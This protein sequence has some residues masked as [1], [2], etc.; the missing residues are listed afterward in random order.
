MLPR[1]IPGATGQGV[2]GEY[3]GDRGTDRRFGDRAILGSVEDVRDGGVGLDEQPERFEVRRGDRGV[4]RREGGHFGEP[5]EDAGAVDVQLERGAHPLQRLTEAADLVAALGHERH[6]RPRLDFSRGRQQPAERTGDPAPGQDQ[7]GRSREEHEDDAEG[8]CGGSRPS[9]DIVARRHG[10]LSVGNPGDQRIDAGQCRG[11]VGGGRRGDGRDVALRSALHGCDQR[12][13]KA[14]AP[15]P[16]LLREG[17]ESSLDVWM[18]RGADP[19]LL[20]EAQLVVQRVGIADDCN[21][22]SGQEIVVDG[23]LLITDGIR[24]PHDLV[25]QGGDGARVSADVE[26]FGFGRRIGHT[27]RERGEQ[28]HAC[29]DDE[30]PISDGPQGPE[31]SSTV[32]GGLVRNVTDGCPSDQLPGRSAGLAGSTDGAPARV[33]RGAAP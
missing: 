5:V 16:C 14:C 17:L 8:A 25:V 15:G 13:R 10:C 12:L 28:G 26:T 32:T 2:Q 20:G 7:A 4:V 11:L 30:E 33:T 31:T 6:V 18:L 19:H 27:D 29:D 24:E 23:G 9:H 22:A 3:F 21:G 1:T